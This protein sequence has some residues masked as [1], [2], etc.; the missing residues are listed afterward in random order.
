[1]E[2][3]K[4]Y[5]DLCEEIEIWK[6]RVKAY[7]AEIEALKKLAKIYGPGEVKG[8]DYSQPKGEGVNQ[9]GFE[10]FLERLQ[11][12]ESH[13]YIHL[14]AIENMEKHKK[15]IEERIK[16][17]NGID[18]KVVYMRDIEGK[19]LVEIA[20]ELGYSYDYI[21]EVSA[22]NKRTHFYPTDKE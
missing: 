4:S 5:K 3:I 21:K 19:S 2:F 22:R 14:E 12:L 20:E 7:E 10:E 1:M 8:L 9:I 18:Y 13:I 16:K 11:K 15:N 6:E 17:L